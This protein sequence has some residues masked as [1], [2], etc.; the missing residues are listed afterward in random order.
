M[1]VTTDPVGFA[2]CTANYVFSKT[3]TYGLGTAGHCAA[4]DALGGYPDVTAYVNPPPGQGTPGFYHIGTF[5]LS[6]N[7]GIGDDFA[8][9]SIYPQYDS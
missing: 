5:V 3:G 8:M 4:K 2:W 9:I 1:T 7:N 6:H